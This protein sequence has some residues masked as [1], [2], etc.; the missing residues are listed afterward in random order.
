M[1][2]G[3]EGGVEEKWLRLVSHHLFFEGSDITFCLKIENIYI[4]FCLFLV[5]YSTNQSDFKSSGFDILNKK[6]VFHKSIFKG[7]KFDSKP[8]FIFIFR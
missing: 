6:L 5:Y 4:K 8:F 7:E 2:E 3:G 1:G